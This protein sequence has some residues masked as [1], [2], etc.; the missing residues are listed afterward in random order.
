MANVPTINTNSWRLPRRSHTA[1]EATFTDEMYR[2]KGLPVDP[3]RG[4]TTGGSGH[5]VVD[6]T[7]WRLPSKEG[8]EARTLE[9]A[10]VVETFDSSGPGL[11]DIQGT[12]FRGFPK[13]DHERATILGSDK[14][15]KAYMRKLTGKHTPSNLEIE[16]ALVKQ[17]LSRTKARQYAFWAA[18][19]FEAKERHHAKNFEVELDDEEFDDLGDDYD[20][21]DF[22]DLDVDESYEPEMQEVKTCKGSL[23]KKRVRVRG[24]QDVGPRRTA[25]DDAVGESVRIIQRRL[26]GLAESRHVEFATGQPYRTMPDMD[27][28]D[29]LLSESHPEYAGSSGEIIGKGQA[30]K[31]TRIGSMKVAKVS[32]TRVTVFSD[33]GIDVG[34]KFAGKHYT[35]TWDGTGY[36]RQG[37]YLHT[38]GIRALKESVVPR[39]QQA[40]AGMTERAPLPHPMTDTRPVGPRPAHGILDDGHDAGEAFVD[41]VLEESRWFFSDFSG[42]GANRPFDEAPG[43]RAGPWRGSDDDPAETPVVRQGKVKG[44]VGKDDEDE[45]EEPEGDEDEGEKKQVPPKAKGKSKAP[46][47][48]KPEEPEE[49]DDEDEDEDEEVEESVLGERDSGVAH[50]LKSLGHHLKSAGHRASSG[51]AAQKAK[52]GLH[53]HLQKF[54]KKHGIKAFGHEPGSSGKKPSKP[55]KPKRSVKAKAKPKTR[56]KPLKPKPSKLHKTALRKSR[57][58]KAKIKAAGAAPKLKKLKRRLR[59][60]LEIALSRSPQ[61][62]L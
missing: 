40:L 11:S 19:K 37:Q 47:K 30:K 13:S 48:K 31:G 55:S 45:D 58:A 41:R 5:P 26:A 16:A 62:L 8:R 22:A 32:P 61:F 54:A 57:A 33:S 59:E 24:R 14:K 52:A 53:H 9:E 12:E 43:G 20:D 35:Y 21:D 6:M 3:D 10:A 51:S 36:K 28:P 4:P 56:P 38:D 25:D 46:P 50:G 42:P 7:G 18:A 39:E 17:G 27:V 29:M 15:F 34:S 60:T 23:L 1:P 44:I 49:G 2:S